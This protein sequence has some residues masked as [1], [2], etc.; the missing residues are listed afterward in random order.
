[1][2]DTYYIASL[3]LGAWM[4]RSGT[5]TT[6]IKDAREFDRMEALIFVKKQKNGGNTVI[7][8]SKADMEW[9]G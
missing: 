2:E 6:D 8:V 7:P 3:K 1:M 9:V 4:S 5:Y